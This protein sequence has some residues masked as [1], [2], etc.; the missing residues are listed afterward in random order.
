MDTKTVSVAE[1]VGVYRR[2]RAAIEE[3]D[4]QYKKDIGELKENLDVVADKLLGICKDQDIDSLR[5]ANG[6]VSRRVKTRYWT[7]DWESLYTTVKEFD[8]PF[9]LEQRI[10]N[11]NMQQFLDDN[12]EAFPPGLQIDRKYVITVRKPTNN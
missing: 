2:I 8:A 12:P 10:H 5:T 4:E 1:L 3:K 6:T 11:T 7:T 9:L